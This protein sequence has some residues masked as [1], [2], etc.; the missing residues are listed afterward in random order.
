MEPSNEIKIIITIIRIR[1]IE[2]IKNKK[3]HI[4]SKLTR[5]KHYLATP[6]T[7]DGDHEILKRRLT[8]RNECLSA[9]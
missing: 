5:K 2:I 6:L 4:F 9:E 7:Q 3:I 8:S 1:I